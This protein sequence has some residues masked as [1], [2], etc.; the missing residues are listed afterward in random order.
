MY[1]HRR[2]TR[3]E[4]WTP[5]KLN[6]YLEVLGRRADGYH[7]I[8]TLMVPI[9]LYD[10][11][12]LTDRDDDR[13]QLTTR[14]ARPNSQAERCGD[15]Q[16]DA[17]PP[18]AENLAYRAVELLRRRAA[19]QAGIELELIKRIPA[20]AGLG[21]GSSDA[22]AALC[23]A[24][25]I[26]GLNWDRPRLAEV[27][28]ELGSDVPFFVYGTSAWCRG[29]GERVEPCRLGA[30][31]YFVVACPTP[32]L[33]TAE[34][35]ARTPPSAAPLTGPS[36]ADTQWA[37]HPHELAH[38]LFNRL[39]SAAEHIAPWLQAVQRQFS[40]LDVLGHQMSG[41]GSA[42]FGVCRNARHALRVAAVMRSR[43]P[44]RVFPATTVGGGPH[45][46]VP[47]IQN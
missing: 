11:L 13:I 29:R 33:S 39:Q 45:C 38:R 6:L 23:G 14:W 18:M 17:L 37:R 1:V 4:I 24:S 9:D 21:G 31:H 41:S 28:A 27:A 16:S 26:W 46:V 8:E 2:R 3:V 40:R 30:R 12:R 43:T 10:T 47:V 19:I 15:G 20:A 5:A 25:K 32:G 36:T 44:Y 42:Y 34:V 7:E 22:A 35:Y